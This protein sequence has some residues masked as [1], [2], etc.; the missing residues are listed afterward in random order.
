MGGERFLATYGG[1]TTEQLLRLESEYRI[2]SLV[3]AFEEAIQRKR[4]R[5]PITPQERYV[6]AVEALQREVNNGGYSQFFINSSHEFIDVVEEALVAIGCPKTAAITR[7]AISA[8]GIT[9]PV[10]GEQAEEVVL[11]E[12]QAVLDALSSCDDRYYNTDE[13]I[14]D[15]LFVWIKEN[16]ARIR[17]GDA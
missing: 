16:Q 12:G 5:G 9:R 13:A 7:D 17:V 15:R 3:L 8:L 11:A 14:A 4:A 2:D 10:S 1:E 6:L